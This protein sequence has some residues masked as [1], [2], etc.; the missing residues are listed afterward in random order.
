MRL[1]VAWVFLSQGG[2]L[3]KYVSRG[4][5]GLHWGGS[6]EVSLVEL[7]LCG[8]RGFVK[9]SVSVFHLKFD[10]RG[11]RFTLLQN[12]QI[13]MKLTKDNNTVLPVENIVNIVVNIFYLWSARIL[14]KCV[15]VQFWQVVALHHCHHCQHQL[16]EKQQ[17]QHPP[18]S[19]L[20]LASL[21]CQ[22]Q[23]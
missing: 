5:L 11:V 19:H 13:G 12:C 22:L 16:Y 10:L 14:T 2:C 15:T 9:E 23:H 6:G 4:C 20:H 18:S 3:G 21:W 8:V 1:F 7:G 17:G